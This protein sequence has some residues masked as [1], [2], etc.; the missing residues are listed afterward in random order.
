MDML[1]SGKDLSG[2]QLSGCPWQLPVMWLQILF[3]GLVLANIGI[4][5][6]QFTDI[7]SL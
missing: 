7:G 2:Q 1:V 3:K 6:K 4:L 5:Y